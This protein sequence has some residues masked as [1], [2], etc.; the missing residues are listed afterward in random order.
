MDGADEDVDAFT[1]AAVASA[2]HR[3]HEHGLKSVVDSALVSVSSMG[4]MV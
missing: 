2:A 4:L 1:A 3:S